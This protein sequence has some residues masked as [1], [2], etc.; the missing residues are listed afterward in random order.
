ME[1]S[2]I[3]IIATLIYADIFAFPLTKNELW[4]FLIADKPQLTD[5]FE[6]A[7][8]KLQ[9]ETI[10]NARDGYYYIAERKKLVEARK[11]NKNITLSK[12]KS[13][14]HFAKL[15][16][17]I[18]SVLLV[19]ISGS[20]A[21]GNGKKND[22]IDF[23]II[24]RRNSLFFTRFCIVFLLQL[25]GARRAPGEKSAENKICVNMLI[26]ES[27]LAFPKS[28]QDLYTAHE[29]VQLKPIFNRDNTYERFLAANNW[30]VNFLPHAFEKRPIKTRMQQ[31]QSFL[32]L[33]SLERLARLLQ[34][35]YMKKRRTK[36]LVETHRLAFHPTD[37]RKY[38]LAEYEKRARKYKI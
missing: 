36:E 38:I 35:W 30:V 10:I 13:A 25:L 26:D 1:K 37:Y 29:I 22:D 19:G 9:E 31:P 5:D 18:P 17:V 6:P 12:E 28:Q 15:L 21:M 32:L 34:L 33:S 2:R 8:K 4:R 16:S 7:L 11:R 3:P 23:F 20:L 27:V 14:R 24:T